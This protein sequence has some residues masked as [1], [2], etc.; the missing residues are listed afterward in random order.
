MKDVKMP[1]KLE[2]RTRRDYMEFENN[3][4]MGVKEIG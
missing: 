1:R 4:K 3:I 2:R